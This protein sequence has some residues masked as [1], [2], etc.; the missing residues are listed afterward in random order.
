MRQWK[1]CT[2]KGRSPAP[3]PTWAAR[4]VCNRLHSGSQPEHNPVQSGRSHTTRLRTVSQH[5]LGFGIK[6]QG[7]SDSGNVDFCRLRRLSYIPFGN[8]TN[9]LPV[10]RVNRDC[11]LYLHE[12][13]LAIRKPLNMIAVVSGWHA[14]ENMSIYSRFSLVTMER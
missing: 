5:N 8:E 4:S 13:S 11:T 7:R 12:P 9:A 10:G 6:F 14:M 1:I 2:G 3:E